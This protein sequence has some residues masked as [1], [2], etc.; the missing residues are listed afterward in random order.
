M[1]HYRCH[2]D[3]LG[4]CPKLADLWQKIDI[5]FPVVKST[6]VFSCRPDL[7][8]ITT[9]STPRRLSDYFTGFLDKLPMFRLN[10]KNEFFFQKSD[11]FS[12]IAI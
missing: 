1:S 3:S 2:N 4:V 5:G 11:R 10:N 8:L 6:P 12:A 7:T 9:A